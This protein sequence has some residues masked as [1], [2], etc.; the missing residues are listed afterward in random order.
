MLVGDLICWISSDHSASVFLLE[1]E[2]PV[3]DSV[4]AVNLPWRSQISG[5]DVEDT[6]DESPRAGNGATQR[7]ELVSV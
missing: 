5:G 4:P 1:R 2:R 7:S 3:G 6:A